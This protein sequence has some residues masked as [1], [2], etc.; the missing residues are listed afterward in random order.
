MEGVREMIPKDGLY[1]PYINVRN[2]NWLKATLL[3]FPHL[4]RMVP[5]GYLRTDSPEMRESLQCSRRPIRSYA[6]FSAV[7]SK[8]LAVRILPSSA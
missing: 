7:R 2:V 5:Q 6:T 8:K 1:Y 4:L 3:C